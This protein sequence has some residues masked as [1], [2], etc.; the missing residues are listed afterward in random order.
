MENKII[1]T[2]P[3][4]KVND[5]LFFI[6]HSGL[7]DQIVNNGLINKIHL[8]RDLYTELSKTDEGL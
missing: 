3:E 8:V 2:L 7:G 1:K 6:P 4:Y 5:T